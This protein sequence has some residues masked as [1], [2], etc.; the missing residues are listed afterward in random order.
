MIKRLARWV[1]E[2]EIADKEKEALEL[3]FNNKQLVVIAADAQNLNKRLRAEV[4]RLQK[5]FNHREE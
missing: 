1:L 4:S 5:L 3:E 2:K